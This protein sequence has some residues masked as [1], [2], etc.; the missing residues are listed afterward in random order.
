MHLKLSTSIVHGYTWVTLCW[1]E[2]KTV[3]GHLWF[4]NVLSV[5]SVI[6]LSVLTVKRKRSSN[7]NDRLNVERCMVVG[8]LLNARH[9]FNLNEV[10]SKQFYSHH[11]R[12]TTPISPF[13]IFNIFYSKVTSKSSTPKAKVA[14]QFY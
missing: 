8:L 1:T 2:I 11:H 9:C 14:S 6:T 7:V 10:V 12:T 5:S 3:Q 4:K 13:Y